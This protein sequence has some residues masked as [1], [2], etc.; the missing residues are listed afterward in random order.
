MHKITITFGLNWSLL[1]SEIK[2]TIVAQIR[3]LSAAYKDIKKNSGPKAL[4]TTRDVTANLIQCN[5]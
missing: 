4:V 1:N 5:V 2:N 3:V